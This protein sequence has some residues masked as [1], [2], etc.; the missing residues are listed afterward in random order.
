ENQN[1]KDQELDNL[2]KK[3]DHQLELVEKKQ[4]EVE[5]LK[6]QH[7]KELENIAGL[8]AEE[9]KLQLEANLKE[10]ARTSAM[11]QIKDIIDEA[12]LTAAKEAKKVVIQTIQRTATES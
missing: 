7:I 8:S 2:R 11:V 10:E 9:A 5:A 1:R 6:A 3:L 4:E 12:K